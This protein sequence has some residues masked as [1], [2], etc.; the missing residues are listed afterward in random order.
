MSLLTTALTCTTAI[1]IV[2][3]IMKNF[4][5]VYAAE[6]SGIDA[7]LIEIETDIHVGLHTFA[8]VG[9]ADKALSE[10]KE[11]VNAALKNIG[12]KPPTRENRKIVVNLAP[13]DIKKTGSHYDLAI[14]VGYLLATGQ[15]K[16]FSTEKTLLVGELSLEGNVRRVHGVLNMTKCAKQLGFTEVVVPLANAAE[17]AL[18]DNITVTPVA[19]LHELIAHLEKR[20]AINPQ[21]TTSP[22]ATSTTPKHDIAE[23]KG[24]ALAK[25]ALT[26]A[27]AGSHNILMVGTPG[28]GKSM[29]A[30]ALTSILP[31]LS[32]PELIEVTQIYSA[33]QL[34]GEQPFINERP[35][36]APHH[37]ASP[38]A[39]IGGGP[40]P[41]PGEVSLSHR[42]VLFLD[43]FPEFRRDLLES[44]R[45]PL[46][47]GSVHISRVRGNMVF[48]S[49][50]MLVAA[51]NPCP[52]GFYGD[53]IQE[54]TCSAHAVANYQKK[55]SGPLLDRIDIQITVPRTP[56]TALRDTHVTINNTDELR[57]RIRAA[58][59]TQQKR[60]AT[61]QS[62][63]TQH[64]N[65]ELTSKQCDTLISFTPQGKTFIEQIMAKS[66]LSARS[67][68][69]ILKVARTIAD[70]EQA[71][72]VSE[73]HL[74]E[75][76]NYRV[77]ST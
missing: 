2:L 59:T 28:S 45:Q 70:L 60:Y 31:P 65:A 50:F 44:L 23:V 53:G 16:E 6:L 67:Y 76:F 72:D 57:A 42:G 10:A 71:P 40:N 38:I 52:C 7:R 64:T 19:T 63:H 30:A 27:A 1:T 25:R 49:R 11:R 32:T 15:L 66:T 62:G 36:R 43:E 12:V 51:M 21:P 20:T 5:R 74:A 69:R 26:I 48:P 68:Y 17:A 55:I 13:A 24:Q 56:L 75:A 33:A 77:R 35:F 37:T 41:R 22:T 47:S 9:L 29:L 18:I 73:A 3:I 61:V 58:R 8:I 46:E 4:S 54:C 14:A 34:L 39:I